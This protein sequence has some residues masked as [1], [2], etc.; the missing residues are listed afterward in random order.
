MISLGYALIMNEIYGAIEGKGLN[1]YAGFLHQDRERHPTVASDLM[2]EWRSVI[3]DS[4]VMSLINGR[5]VLKDGFIRR[6]N[7]V[8]LKDETFKVFI[9]KYESK[10][11]TDMSYLNHDSGRMSFRK[12]LW[13]QASKLA[14]AID[15]EDYTIYEPICIK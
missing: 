10:M 1:V 9:K 15:E 11:R 12:A 5:E 2:E 13:I 8:F 6:D 3:V 14:K 7:G 4:M